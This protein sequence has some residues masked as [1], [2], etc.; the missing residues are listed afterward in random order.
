MLGEGGIAATP[1]ASLLDLIVEL[2]AGAAFV[3][4]TEEAITS[5][6]LNPLADWLSRQ[7][8]WS[9]MPFVLLTTRGG[10]IERNPAAVRYLDVLGNVT[11]LERPFH[12][13]TLISLARSALRARK[14]QYEARARLAELREGEA[15]Y[16]T[17][18]DTM[19]EGFAVIEFLDGPEGELSDYVHVQANPAYERHTGIANVVGQK[20]R[21]MVPDEA[22]GWIALYRQ[23]L[24]SGEP[25]RFERELVATHRHLELSAFRIEPAHRREVAVLFQDVTERKRAE[26][27]LRELNEGLEARV[28]AT[29]AERETVIA[30]LHEAQ[31]LETIGQLTGGVAHDIN[32]LLTPITGALDLLNRRYGADDPRSARLLD[33][34]LQ[35][36]ERAKILVSRLLGF[37][38]RQALET[39]A[40]DI[41]QLFEGMRDLIA[42]SIGPAIEL[43]MLPV[44]DLPAGIA[45]PNQLELAILNLCVNA[46]DAM[47]GGGV[48]TIAADRVVLGPDRT[49]KL[50][51]GAYIRMTVIDTGSGMDEVTL[52]KAVEP[53]FS[54]KDVGKGTGL[55]LSMVHGLAAQLGGAFELQSSVGQGTRADLYLPVATAGTAQS[56]ARIPAARKPVR[57]LRLLLIDD[58]ELVR[59]GTAEMLRELGHEVHEAAG[60]AQALAKLRTG[61][62]IDAVVS[63][64]MMPRMNGTEVAERIR[65]RHPHMPILI[66]T[67]YAGGDLDLPLPQ[68]AKPFRQVDIAMAID[69]LIAAPTV[70]R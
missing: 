41:G 21:E 54:T 66:V 65:E 16:R 49:G 26:R 20:V 10:G 37:A 67:G 31:K 4:V 42:S 36:A 55:G 3:L 47:E 8:E 63:D 52:A 53:F 17:L 51:P 64:Y 69:K 48:L 33:G 14:R 28:T 11:F 38:R 50:N 39:R 18:F 1:C 60:G 23:V 2:D 7:Q 44:H 56:A 25:I 59:R 40:V 62:Q 9:D 61:I 19:D 6:D 68:L 34:A 46:R 24:V 58:E 45:D 43:R 32:N 22:E 30:Q 12:P 70:Y 35:S 29:V 13:T 27:E 15:R 57:P 5:A